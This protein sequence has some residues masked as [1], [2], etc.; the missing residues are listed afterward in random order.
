MKTKIIRAIK[1]FRRK[2]P[3]SFRLV[4]ENKS[5]IHDNPVKKP[6]ATAVVNFP[7]ADHA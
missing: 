4:R 6:K 5:H 3:V 2:H 1:K 7:G